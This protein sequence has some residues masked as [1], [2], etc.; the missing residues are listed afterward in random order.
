MLKPRDGCGGGGC[1]RIEN[2]EQ[3]RETI[4]SLD[5]PEQWIVQMWCIGKHCSVAMLVDEYG[6]C[7]V[8]GATEQLLRYDETGF[9]YLGARGPLAETRSKG[10]GKLVPA[11][12]G[13]NSRR[14][15]VGR[16]RFTLI[17]K[18]ALSFVTKLHRWKLS[19]RRCIVL[20]E[21]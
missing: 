6:T 3:L 1:K 12:A 20:L 5:N 15:G 14:S 21:P 2:W 10:D 17:P 18:M 4:H 9:Q 11:S 16:C 7:R 8:L 13:V 19:V